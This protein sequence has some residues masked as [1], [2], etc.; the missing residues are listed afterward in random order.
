[1]RRLSEDRMDV[2]HDNLTLLGRTAQTCE[3]VPRSI[4]LCAAAQKA[5]TQAILDRRMPTAQHFDF[6]KPTRY[7]QVGPRGPQPEIPRR[8]HEEINEEQNDAE[9]SRADDGCRH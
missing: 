7:T 2:E 3:P 4:T 1:M 5:K 6:G 8:I 9:H